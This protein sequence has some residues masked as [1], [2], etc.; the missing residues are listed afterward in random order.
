MA[1]EQPWWIAA[2]ASCLVWAAISIRWK[3]VREPLAAGFFIFTCGTIGLATIQPG[4][5]INAMAF[6]AVN[7]VGFG[8]A[9]IL[10]VTAIQYAAPHH[11]IGTVTA[12]TISTRALGASVT[13]AICGAAFGDSF[14]GKLP[15]YVGHA[16]LSAGLPQSSLGAFIGALASNHF[17]DL[18]SIPGVTPEIVS[19]G[20]GALQHAYADSLR[21]VF[22]IVAPFGMFGTILCFFMPSFEATMNKHIDE[23]LEA[24]DISPPN[25]E[26]KTTK[27]QKFA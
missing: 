12:L 13:T 25:P 14:G 22:I 6:S 4:Q 20:T 21:L 17:N 23:P 10:I 26:E 24:I 5:N 2:F 15:V 16:A 1:R 8:A 18:L 3:R 27:N 19:A 7:G 9:L 11:L